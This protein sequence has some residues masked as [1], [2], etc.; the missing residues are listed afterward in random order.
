METETR[1]GVR[2]RNVD[3]LLFA[4]QGVILVTFFIFALLYEKAFALFLF[5]L[6]GVG[7]E[8]FRMSK[9]NYVTYRDSYFIVRSLFKERAR[10][11]ADQFEGVLSPRYSIIPFSNE[12]I[13]SFKNGRN[14]KIMAGMSQRETE[15][16][17]NDLI[18]DSRHPTN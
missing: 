16:L 18:K 15:K 5:M 4:G 2:N 10:I 13:I 8:C 9:R 3:R 17:I 14:F 12:L 1:I 6:A 11:R 7:F